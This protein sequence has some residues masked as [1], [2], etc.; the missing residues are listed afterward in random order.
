MASAAAVVV[1]PTPPAP[2]VTTTSL[3]ASSCSRAAPCGVAG[4][5]SIAGPRSLARVAQL[6]GTAARPTRRAVA[7]GE[8]LRHVAASAARGQPLPQVVPGARPAPARRSTASAAASSTLVTSPGPTPLD[9]DAP[10]QASARAEVVEHRLLVVGNS[11][12][13]TRLTTTAASPTA[14]W[15]E[16]VDQLER[17]VDRQL[18]GRGDDDDARLARVGEDLDHPA[19]LVADQA[20]LHEVVDRPGA[21]SWPTMWP[22]A[23]ASTTTRS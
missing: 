6:V 5:E 13:S 17:L 1:L 12:G 22:E 2:H 4:G 3:A 11:S 21:A 16:P 14:R 20:D 18:L 23:A 8:Q 19:R 10:R 7:A 9:S 15:P